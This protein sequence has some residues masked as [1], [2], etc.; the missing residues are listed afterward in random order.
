MTSTQS[1]PPQNGR[2]LKGYI[3]C[4]LFHWSQSSS[5]A[6]SYSPRGVRLLSRIIQN[7]SYDWLFCHGTEISDPC[8][9]AWLSGVSEG[10]EGR[11]GKEKQKG[12]Q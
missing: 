7:Y 3:Y 2:I 1:K 4:L 12:R 5:P 10:E 6:V 9:I 11:R 8:W